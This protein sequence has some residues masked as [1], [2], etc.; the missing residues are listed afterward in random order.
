L[1]AISPSLRARV[2]DLVEFLELDYRAL[3]GRFDRVVSVGG[4]G[5]RTASL[6]NLNAPRRAGRRLRA[7]SAA[8][9]ESARFNCRR[10]GAT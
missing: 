5:R 6:A 8:G 1:R 2:T 9:A 4:G 10:N 7:P 3:E